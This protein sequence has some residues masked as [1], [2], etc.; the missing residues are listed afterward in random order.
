MRPAL[1]LSSLWWTTEV[2]RPSASVT[3]RTRGDVELT[4]STE[5]KVSPYSDLAVYTFFSSWNVDWLTGL[6]RPS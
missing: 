1:V 5:V 2:T 3:V 6:S 4:G